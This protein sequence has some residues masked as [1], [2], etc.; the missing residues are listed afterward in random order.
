MVD[1]GNADELLEEDD[2][3]DHGETVLGLVASLA[4]ICNDTG[5][6]FLVLSLQKSINEHKYLRKYM[7]N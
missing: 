5:L 6:G 2:H 4:T 1:F 7:I 3:V